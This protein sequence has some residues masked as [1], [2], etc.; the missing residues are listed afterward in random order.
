MSI[1]A[2]TPVDGLRVNDPVD[3]NVYTFHVALA[4]FTMLVV[5]DPVTVT[6]NADDAFVE[7]TRLL[8]FAPVNPAPPALVT[9]TARSTRMR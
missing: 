5:G 6:P 1:S 8:Y 9:L 3:V 2:R 7:R 4:R